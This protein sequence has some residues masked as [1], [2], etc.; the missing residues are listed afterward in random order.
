M[1]ADAGAFPAWKEADWRKAAEAALKGANLDTLA[2]S[3]ADG[4]RIEPLYPPGEGP[5]PLQADGPWRVIARLDHPDAGEA[6][7]QALDDLAGGADG[8][9]V[10]FSGAVG[11]Y[12]FGLR[13]SDPA[14]LHAAFDGVR[15]DQGLR[16]ELDLGRDAA[17]HAPEFR[18]AYRTVGRASRRLRRVLRTRSLRDA[19]PSGPCPPTGTRMSTPSSTRRLR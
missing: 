5:R 16:F 1:G 17:D 6:N 7:A 14:T 4:V 9:Q 18:G 15:F 2:S 11:A 19:W 8:L 12:G 3:T 13:R 10:V